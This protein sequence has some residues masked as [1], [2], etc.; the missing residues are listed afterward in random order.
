MADYKYWWE[1]MRQSNAAKLQTPVLTLMKKSAFTKQACHEVRNKNARNHSFLPSVHSHAIKVCQ[2]S[3]SSDDRP[4]SIVFRT[5][6]EFTWL[7]SRKYACPRII[8][9]SP[10]ATTK[11]DSR[12]Q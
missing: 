6:I 5:T 1:V 11:S 12:V 7:M 9:L 3:M 10:P 2:K 4:H 8:S